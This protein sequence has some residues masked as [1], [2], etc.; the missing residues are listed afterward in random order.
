MDDMTMAKLQADQAYRAQ[1]AGLA[2][3]PLPS[4]SI[5]ELQRDNLIQ[6]AERHQKGAEMA[7]KALQLMDEHP[8][9]SEYLTIIT[10][11]QQF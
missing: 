3:A 2:A 10:E 11:L 1:C 8:E 5:T 9:I 7:Q 6:R 4:K